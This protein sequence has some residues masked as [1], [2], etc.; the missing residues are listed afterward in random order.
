MCKELEILKCLGGLEGVSKED[1]AIL[2]EGFKNK[3]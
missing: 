2:E 1:I 3:K